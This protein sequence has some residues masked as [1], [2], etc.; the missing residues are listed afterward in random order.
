MQ[1]NDSPLRTMYCMATA[2]FGAATCKVLRRFPGTANTLISRF[3]AGLVL[4]AMMWRHEID[5]RCSALSACE[6]LG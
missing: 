3:A 2:T 1:A 6:N 5:E 4:L